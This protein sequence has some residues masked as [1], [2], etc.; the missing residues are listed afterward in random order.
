MEKIYVAKI[1]KAVGLKGFSKIYIDSDFPEQFKKN[2]RFFTDR[3]QELIIE[4]YNS[5]NDTVKFKGIDTMDEVKKLTNRTLYSTLE[6]TKDNCKLDKDQYFWFDLIDCQI[7]EEGETLGVV[8]DIQRLP[9]SD[10]LSIQTS[11]ELVAKDLAKNFLIPY[12]D[13]YILD[14]EL[15]SKTITT[16]GAKDILE[17]S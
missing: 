14:V 8:K 16:K 6:D 13:Q 1:G 5:K 7:V 3:N 9:L 12:L 4:S 2:S 15:D 11:K 10:Y 17:A